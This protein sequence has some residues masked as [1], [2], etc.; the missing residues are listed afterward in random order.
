MSSEYNY[1]T[2]YFAY[3]DSLYSVAIEEKYSKIYTE[4]LLIREEYYQ[5]ATKPHLDWFI[6]MH[7]ILQIDARLQILTDLLKI[8]LKYPDCEDVFNESDI[9]EISRNDAKNY[10]KEV[11]GI[12][13]NEPVPHS[14]LH[15]VPNGLK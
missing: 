13:L 6:Q 1:L 4:Y 3:F 2:R 11:C 10:Y 5:L 12:R 15:F 9:I 7:Q 14:L 8:E